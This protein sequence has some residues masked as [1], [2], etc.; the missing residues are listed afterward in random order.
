MEVNFN[1]PNIIKG[2]L[3]QARPQFDLEEAKWFVIGKEG[4]I[5][6]SLFER[7]YYE[8]PRNFEAKSIDSMKNVSAYFNAVQSFVDQWEKVAEGRGFKLVQ[9][10]PRSH[11]VSNGLESESFIYSAGIGDATIESASKFEEFL[12]MVKDGH[13]AIQEGYNRL[14]QTSR[15]L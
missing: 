13:S 4:G 15:R 5:G 2:Y 7:D 6:Y 3:E 9:I 12:Q 14:K 10:D 11:K 1:N 8:L